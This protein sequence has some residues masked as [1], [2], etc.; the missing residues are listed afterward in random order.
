MS[1]LADVWCWRFPQQSWSEPWRREWRC[2]KQKFDWLN[3][4]CLK[5]VGFA[6]YT[7]TVFWL[8]CINRKVLLYNPGKIKNTDPIPG[9]GKRVEMSYWRCKTCPSFM[10]KS[11]QLWERCITRHRCGLTQNSR[12]SQA[13]QT[14]SPHPHPFPPFHRCLF[15]EAVLRLT[16]PLSLAF[17][18]SPH[19][20]CNQL[21]VQTTHA[22]PQCQRIATVPRQAALT[23]RMLR[24]G[25][26]AGHGSATL[27]TADSGDTCLAFLPSISGPERWY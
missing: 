6:V 1:F 16:F 2:N 23:N 27:I 25:W 8:E 19:Y 5:V 14:P 17:F 22:R 13:L 20:T 18:P 26:G 9:D 3:R 4:T 21:A 10:G 7:A 24:K 11:D 15:Q 12:F